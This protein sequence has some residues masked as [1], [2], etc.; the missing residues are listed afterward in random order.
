MGR[1]PWQ[2]HDEPDELLTGTDA[3]MDDRN[4]AIAELG[5]ALAVEIAR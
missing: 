2:E 3:A 5:A 1:Y 4:A